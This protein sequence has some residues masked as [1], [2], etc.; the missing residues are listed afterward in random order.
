MKE[1]CI[2]YARNIQFLNK[3]EFLKLFKN[4]ETNIDI[5]NQIL[6]S[7]LKASTDKESFKEFSKINKSGID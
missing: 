2:P 4:N 5:L 3:K 1:I 7:H 6:N